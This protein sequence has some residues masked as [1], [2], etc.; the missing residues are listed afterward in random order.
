MNMTAKDI[1]DFALKSIDM[2]TQFPG[3]NNKD[4]YTEIAEYSGVSASRIRDFHSG[5]HPNLSVA[6]LDKIVEGVKQSMR[7]AAA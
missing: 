1:Q 4:V 5:A 7:K 3:R 6:L 2:L